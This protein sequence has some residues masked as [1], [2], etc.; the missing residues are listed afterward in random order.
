MVARRHP[1]VAGL[2]AWQRLD[3]I[4]R[5]GGRLEGRSRTKVTEPDEQRRLSARPDEPARR[6]G[7]GRI[8]L[9]R[10]VS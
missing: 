9:R 1:D 6:V 2:A 8:R 7:P 5:E 4:E 10:T 3:A